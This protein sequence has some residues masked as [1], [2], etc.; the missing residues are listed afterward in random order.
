ME[1]RAFARN[2]FSETVHRQASRSSVLRRTHGPQPAPSFATALSILK[3]EFRFLANA[4]LLEHAFCVFFFVRE[5]V[6]L[7]ALGLACSFSLCLGGW[8]FVVWDF[9]RVQVREPPSASVISGRKTVRESVKPKL[10]TCGSSD[11]NY[12]LLLEI[13]SRRPY[14]VR[15]RDLRFLRRTHGPQPVPSFATALSI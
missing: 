2:M 14:T 5:H 9:S 8:F 3:I 4:T 13:C 10:S 7:D 6:D 15:L 11:E 1:L 12:A